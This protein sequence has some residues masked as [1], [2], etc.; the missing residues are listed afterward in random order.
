MLRARSRRPVPLRRVVAAAATALAVAA[1]PAGA[2][3]SIMIGDNDGFGFGVPDDGLVSAITGG[4]WWPGPGG[5]GSLWDGRS[6][7]EQAA[8]NGAQLTDVWSALFP[9]AGSLVCCSV[10]TDSV[11]F[12]VFPVPV[13]ITAATLT[14]D[15]GD[16]QAT[17]GAP[18]TVDYNGLLQSW[19][20]DDGFLVTRVRTFILDAAVLASINATQELRIKI[21]HADSQDLVAW[22][23]FQLDATTRVSSVPEPGTVALVATGL[24]ALGG[25]ARRRA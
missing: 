1:S 13:P 8:T 15:F 20:Y 21:D 7:A 6:A 22:D 16:F 18:I 5:G 23:Y 25:V 19:A 4:P 12:V 3:L 9:N 14:V 10:H 2:Q 17:Q 24:L 11:G